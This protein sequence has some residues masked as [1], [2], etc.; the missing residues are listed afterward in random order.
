M[1]ML[2]YIL[3]GDHVAYVA[4]TNILMLY[5]YCDRVFE[6]LGKWILVGF[7]LCYSV[8]AQAFP[9]LSLPSLKSYRL[10]KRVYWLL[11]NY[12]LK[13]AVDVIRES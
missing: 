9:L 4:Y 2:P 11:M 6:F 8:T 1:L 5:L 12:V 3:S 7:R 13:R 10:S